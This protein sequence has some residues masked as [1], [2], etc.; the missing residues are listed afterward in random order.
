MSFFEVLRGAVNMVSMA[1]YFGYKVNDR[2]NIR[3]Y[4]GDK[5]KQI[6]SLNMTGKG[7]NY[8]KSTRKGGTFVTF[9]INAARE[10]SRKEYGGWPAMKEIKKLLI[11]HKLRADD[12]N[13]LY[14]LKHC[15]HQK[16]LR[17]KDKKP[18]KKRVPRIDYDKP[19]R[20]KRWFGLEPRE[21]NPDD[22]PDDVVW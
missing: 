6:I 16:K 9:F 7:Y 14:A 21:L 12:D 2:G 15:I 4:F 11:D 10:R 1:Q 18:R 17:G 8:W 19:E 20:P 22:I 13:F 5:E 3:A